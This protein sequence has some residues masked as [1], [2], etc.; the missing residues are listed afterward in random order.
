MA[1]VQLDSNGNVTG[2][3][4]NP[5]PGNPAWQEIPDTDPRIAAFQ[6]AQAAAPPKQVHLPDLVALLQA[7]GVL[8]ATDIAGIMK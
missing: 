2:M 5:Q 4:A 7:K 6:A 8:S 3:F 1:Y